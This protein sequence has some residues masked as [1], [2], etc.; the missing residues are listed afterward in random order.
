MKD[1]V[2]KFHAMQERLH[3]LEGFEESIHQ[4]LV[5]VTSKPFLRPS[6]CFGHL[7]HVCA[8]K[9]TGIYVICFVSC[10]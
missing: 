1:K 4:V 8:P 3:V 10:Q 6:S 5:H 9:D 2:E 7:I